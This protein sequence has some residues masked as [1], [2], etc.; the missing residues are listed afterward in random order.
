MQSRGRERGRGRGGERRAGGEGRRERKG[1]GEGE[2]EENKWEREGT[3]REEGRGRV[4]G[5][6]GGKVKGC[7]SPVQGVCTCIEC[8]YCTCRRSWLI[9]VSLSALAPFSSPL[10]SASSLSADF[11]HTLKS[12]TSSRSTGTQK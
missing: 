6:Q 4:E 10:A 7:T 3:G 8:V 2:R 12:L 5:G 9:L 11:K 1:R